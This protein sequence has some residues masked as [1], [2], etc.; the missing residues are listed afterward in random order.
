MSIVNRNNGRP[1][2]ENALRIHFLINEIINFK[3]K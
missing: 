3:N 1:N 2:F